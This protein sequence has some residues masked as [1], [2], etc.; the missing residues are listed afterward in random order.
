MNIHTWLQF[1]QGSVQQ[2]NKS[3]VCNEDVAGVAVEGRNIWLGW[4]YPA[5]LSRAALAKAAFPMNESI[6]RW[7]LAQ[8]ERE[9]WKKRKDNQIKKTREDLFWKRLIE[10]YSANEWRGQCPSGELHIDPDTQKAL[11]DNRQREK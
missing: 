8:W 5:P 6:L 1:C 9:G 4:I 10:T 11:R 2:L 7:K 3:A